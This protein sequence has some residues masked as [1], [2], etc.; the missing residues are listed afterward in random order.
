V[1]DRLRILLSLSTEL[2]SEHD[3]RAILLK[4]TNATR[5]LLCADRCSV[6]LHDKQQ[7]QLWTIVADG[8]DEIRI[9]DDKGIAGNVLRTGKE[10]NIA[11]VYEYAHFNRST[12]AA[13]GY[14]TKTMLA[15]PLVDMSGACLGV[16]QAIN[17]LDGQPFGADDADL[18]RHVAMYA[19][20]AIES[21]HLYEQ[22]RK[23]HEDVIYK[24][25]H[26]TKFKDPETQNHIIRVGLYC[27][28][29]AREA[30]IAADEREAI[31]LAAPMH[32]IGKVGVPDRILQKPGSLEEDEWTVMKQHTLY[33]YEILKGADSHLLEVAALV[34]LEHHER[35]AGGGYP[36]DKAGDTISLCGRMTALADVF[37]ALTSKRH[38]KA[39]WDQDRVVALFREERGRHF[40]PDLTDI[41]LDCAD[42]FYAIKAQYRDE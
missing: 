39:A 14:R 16:F 10:L 1:D 11:D 20:S 2:A 29:L 34:A 26:A 23:A 21:A 32:D 6:F 25:S 3:I 7:A 42:E 12:D 28:V 38:Y 17:R 9:P 22:L 5:K 36:Y 8:V 19:G 30:G 37:D 35:W 27:D 24:L 31:R 13:T 4:L 41:L 18:L 33:G 15:V 40:A